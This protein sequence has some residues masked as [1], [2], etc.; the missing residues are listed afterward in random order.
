MDLFK[1]ASIRYKLKL[2]KFQRISKS[3]LGVILE[4]SRGDNIDHQQGGIGLMQFDSEIIYD[5]T[6]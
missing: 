3:S 6:A 1:N 4:K 2:T 5:F